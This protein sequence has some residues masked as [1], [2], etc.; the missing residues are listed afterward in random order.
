MSTDFG[1]VNDGYLFR[2]WGESSFVDKTAVR[3][4]D[5][6]KNGFEFWGLRNHDE[7]FLEVRML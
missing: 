7:A 5:Y 1:F 2:A 6:G 3:R 4:E